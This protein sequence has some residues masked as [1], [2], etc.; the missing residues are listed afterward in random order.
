MREAANLST[1]DASS[2]AWWRRIGAL[3]ALLALSILGAS[4]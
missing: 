3:G 4:I 1:T 2:N